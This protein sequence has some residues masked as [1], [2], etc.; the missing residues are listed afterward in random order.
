MKAEK[1]K[2]VSADGNHHASRRLVCANRRTGAYEALI[3]T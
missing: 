1:P 2:N 3:P